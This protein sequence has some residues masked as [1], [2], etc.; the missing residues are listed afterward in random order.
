MNIYEE[1][2]PYCRTETQRK[3]IQACADH[4]S[5]RKGAA[6][7]G[8][9]KAAVRE[10]INRVKSYRDQVE[11]AAESLGKTEEDI[12]KDLQ[13][14]G[15]T[16]KTIGKKVDAANSI[17]TER[18][19]KESIQVGRKTVV[20]PDTQVKEGVPLFHLKAASNYIVEKKP[21]TIVVIGD[22]WDMPS[23]NKFGSSKELEG[24]RVLA[25]LEIGKYAM[26]LFLKPIKECEG[27]EPRLIFCTG[28]HDPQVRIPRAIESAPNLEGLLIDDTDEW[29]ESRGFED[30]GFLEIVDIEGI[31][32]SHY[33]QNPHSAKKAPLSGA[34]DTMLKNC[35]H[36]FVQGHTQG[37]KMGKHYLSDGSVRVGIVAGSFYLHDEEFMG[38]QGNEHWRG[39]IQL[40]DMRNGSADICELSANYLIR[41]YL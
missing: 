23:L 35:G 10:I 15:Y 30:Y 39:I 41:R 6:S 16:G 14:R 38:R 5:Y 27:Y 37:L 9:G 11:S 33:F 26:D 19:Y 1:L 40:N 24:Q 13:A 29:L 12:I 3:T 34:M 22:W 36:S 8:R 18:E 2:L 21:D 17:V 7:I 32:F 25:D 4:N 31:W 20:I 28:N